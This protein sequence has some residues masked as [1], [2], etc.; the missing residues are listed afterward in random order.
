MSCLQR[1]DKSSPVSAVCGLACL[2]LAA[3]L[4]SRPSTVW[5]AR[6]TRR[7][8]SSVQRPNPVDK[9]A[10]IHHFQHQCTVTP[11]ILANPLRKA[12]SI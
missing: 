3:L 4:S 5:H 7:E 11:W 1:R 6:T 8:N 10:N 9:A 12:N 2:P